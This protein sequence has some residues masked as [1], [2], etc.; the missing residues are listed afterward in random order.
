M[1]NK[2]QKLLR[3]PW[4]ELSKR[5]TSE[6]IEKFCPRCCEWWP[7]DDEFFTFIQSRGHYHSHCNA[8]R[9][10]SSRIRRKKNQTE[11]KPL[12]ETA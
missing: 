11:G 9:A 8:C 5:K 2:T 10:E 6:G 1:L 12:M 7:H 4:P 3:K